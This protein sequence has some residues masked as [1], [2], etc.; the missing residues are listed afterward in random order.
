[1]LRKMAK[2][3]INFA[4]QVYE[5][6]FGYYQVPKLLDLDP[7]IEQSQTRYG[8]DLYKKDA[9]GRDV[10]SPVTL[11][12]GKKENSNDYANKVTLPYSTVAVTAS[13]KI[14][15]TE[16][17]NR[18]GSVNEQININDYEFQING[19]VISEQALPEDWLDLFAQ[20]FETKEPMEIVNPITD[21]Y[22]TGNVIII[23]HHL[24]EMRGI[25]NAQAFSFKA[26]TEVNLELEV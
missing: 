22:N 13:K 26:R 9:Y 25:S 2:F 21:F 23:S 14:V 18:K 19:V 8:T 20:I 17:V 1:M 10:F 11:A 24:P 5:N 6:T 7:K 16:L 15:N 12:W 4:K 3:N